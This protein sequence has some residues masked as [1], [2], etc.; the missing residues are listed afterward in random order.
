MVEI[1]LQELSRQPS[2]SASWTSLLSAPAELG[3]QTD[4]SLGVIIGESMGHV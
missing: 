4:G 2:G 3:E 1:D